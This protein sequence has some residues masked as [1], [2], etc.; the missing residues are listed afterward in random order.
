MSDIPRPEHPR[1]DLRRDDAWWLNLNG[2]WQF[3]TDRGVSGEA[4]GYPS[5]RELDREIVVPFCPESRL[6]GVGDT[7]F[8]NSVWYRRFLDVPDRWDGRRVLLHV[9][10][11]DYETTVWLNGRELGRH[12]GGYTPIT[13]ELTDALDGDGRDELVVRA[14]DDVRSGIPHG[15][16]SERYH[17]YGCLY[18]R[19]T[20]IWQTVWV[21]AVPQ[22][23]VENIHVWPDLEGEAFSVVLHVHGAGRYDGQVTA[24]ADGEAVGRAGFAGGGSGACRVR[25]AL[26]EARAWCPADPF[27]YQIRVELEG[28]A[29]RDEVT[30][31]GG[32]RSF[33]TD[34]R[35]FLLNGEPIFLRTVLDQGFYPDG[36]YTAP[37]ADAL[38]ADID[39]S[40]AFGF[41]GARLH[42]KVFEPLFLHMCDRKGYL[43]FGEYADWQHRFNDGDYVHAMADQWREAL[44]RD[45]SH[46]AIIGWCPLNESGG[47][48]RTRYGEWLTRHL[49]RITKALDPS[50][51]A[52]DTSGYQH[53]ETDVWDTHDYEQD[54]EQFAARYEPLA[55]GA[56]AEFETGRRGMNYDGTS[57]FFHSE[58][59]GIAWQAGDVPEKA[60]GYGQG[61]TT[62]EEFLERF[63]GLVEA[64]L[65]NPGV[66]GFCYTQLTDVEQE[67]NG[68]LT[69]DR[70]PKF[71]PAVIASILQQEA[72]V[73]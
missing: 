53:F 48:D 33:R 18:T 52:L 70:R 4:R 26:E 61:P 10:A 19:T 28:E 9:G 25:L 54:V 16:Q 37:S 34:G 69:Y 41:N 57:P 30:T 21:E 40:M 11:C 43:V 12:T 64:L 8:H 45:V 42:E 29:G 20:G 6:S 36:I 50:R 73:E 67:V 22:T 63:R 24:L 32:L 3:E 65:K 59:G 31:W 17:S 47:A 66:A 44:L 62:R 56:W 1:P 35:K 14:V 7:D 46:P 51:P 38:A 68:L 49:Y 15:K 39:H 72:A 13:V 23:Y 5:G 55:R 27:L 60:W 2:T 58:F 71:D